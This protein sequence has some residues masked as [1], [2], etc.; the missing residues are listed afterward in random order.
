MKI[1]FFSNPLDFFFLL[2]SLKTIA[3]LKSKSFRYICCV[4]AHDRNGTNR[5]HKNKYFIKFNGLYL[6]FGFL[7]YCL[8]LFIYVGGLPE[9]TKYKKTIK[10]LQASFGL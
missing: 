10:G 7:L 1:S 3:L 6:H 2:L 9:K 4:V 5:G 8:G